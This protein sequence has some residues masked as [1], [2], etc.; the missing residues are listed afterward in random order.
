MTTPENVTPNWPMPRSCP[1]LPPDQYAEL[2]E[3]P[4]HQV[5]LDDGTPAWIVSR[6]SDVREAMTNPGRQQGSSPPNDL[7]EPRNKRP[8]GSRRAAHPPGLREHTIE[9]SMVTENIS[10]RTDASPAA[11]TR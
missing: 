6:H 2:R 5:R 3:E 4:P 1:M 7:A 10:R 9:D 8:D 11:R